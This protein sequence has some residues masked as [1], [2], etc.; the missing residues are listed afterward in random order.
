LP[1]SYRS[2]ARIFLAQALQAPQSAF[3]AFRVAGICPETD[4][5]IRGLC[6]GDQSMNVLRTVAFSATLSFGFV[7]TAV[8]VDPPP[9]SKPSES[10]SW[11]A[12]LLGKGDAKPESKTDTKSE[13]KSEGKSDA[14]GK[15]TTPLRPSI[16]MAPLSAELL[17]EAVKAEEA[18]CTRRL[19]VCA[20]LREAAITTNDET[21]QRQIDEL[22]RQA[23]EV[24]QA[25]I[26]RMG[27]RG[28]RTVAR[29]NQ[30]HESG[31]NTKT[32]GAK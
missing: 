1:E 5:G 11:T 23:I 7:A 21:L 15:A 24:C 25:R 2:F 3:T 28:N 20:K 26:A 31:L 10:P 30:N 19:D 12:R 8:A 22:E 13:A 16:I 4:W 17:A 29:A 18:A 14:T 9:P 27:L 32:G 6:L